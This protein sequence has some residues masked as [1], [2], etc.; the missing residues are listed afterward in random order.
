MS[1][2]IIAYRLQPVYATPPG[3]ISTA[4]V[5]QCAATGRVLSGDGGGGT[6]L[7]PEVVE[8]LLTTPTQTPDLDEEPPAER[9]TPAQLRERVQAEVR[10]SGASEFCA[11][12]GVDHAVAVLALLDFIAGRRNDPGG[13]ILKAL[14]LELE[15]VASPRANWSAG[16]A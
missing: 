7:A 4:C 16:S 13:T 1:R 5:M 9:L 14:R 10:R 11:R 12:L 8:K 6:F 15:Y 2:E 3:G